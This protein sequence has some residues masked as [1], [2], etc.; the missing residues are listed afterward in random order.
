MRV[1]YVSILGLALA[2]ACDT[3]GG[4]GIIAI[5]GGTAATHVVFV[6][7]PTGSAA[8]AVIT[9]TVV[10]NAETA[11]GAKDST[12]KGIIAIT[13]GGSGP[14]T[15]TGTT[16][17]VATAGQASFGD[18]KISAAGTYTLTASSPPLASA[19]SSPFAVTP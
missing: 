5:A 16:S 4:G 7:P 1:G 10:V 13:L 8:G 15:L 6:I 9:P 2:A 3:S 18:L 17:V 12:F 14:G 19:T 11:S